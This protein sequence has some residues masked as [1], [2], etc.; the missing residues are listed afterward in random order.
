MN[1]EAAMKKLGNRIY[2]NTQDEHYGA[3]EIYEI[4]YCEVDEGS[5]FYFEERRFSG[6]SIDNP[7][8]RRV[9]FEEYGDIDASK[10]FSREDRP[11][12]FL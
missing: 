11:E 3:M 4:M 6:R 7:A 5:P 9:F 1:D 8:R 12:F 2:Y 10:F